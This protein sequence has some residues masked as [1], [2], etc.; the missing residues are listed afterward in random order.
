MLIKDWM[1]KPPLTID[2]AASLTE[3]AEMFRTRVISMLPVVKKDR[4][5]GVMTDGDVKKALPSDA[6]TLDRFEMRDLMGR[7]KIDTIMSSPVISI[8]WDRTV[9]Q[10]ARL[11]LGSGISGL[12]VMENGHL[13]GVLTKSDVFRCFASYTGT[14]N[15]GQIFGFNLEDVPGLVK[16]ISE[17][18]GSAGGRLSSIMSTQGPMGKS[19]RRVFFYTRDVDP[20]Q[21]ETLVNRL[22]GAGELTYVADLSR[23]LDRLY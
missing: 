21:F 18:I 6:T 11:M 10:A 20:A 3:A 19:F 15:K 12:P 17:M 4:V 13:V 1:S 7:V 9:D 8:P 2:H 16:K 23:D 5:V 22:H 14:V